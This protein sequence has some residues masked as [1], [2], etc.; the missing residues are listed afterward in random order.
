ML[1]HGLH[2]F[3]AKTA[4]I[5]NVHD[6]SEWFIRFDDSHSVCDLSFLKNLGEATRNLRE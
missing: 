6:T 5:R 4:N 3:K 1:R 2:V